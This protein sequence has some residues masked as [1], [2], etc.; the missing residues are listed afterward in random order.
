M[1]VER[2]STDKATQLGF[3]SIQL[4]TEIRGRCWDNIV[5]AGLHQFHQGKGY[6]PHS[7][8]LARHLD[9][10]IY[11]LS[12]EKDTP[13]AQGESAIPKQIMFCWIK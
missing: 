10:P 8:E 6:D 7:Q 2:L 9:L 12:S 4:T 11:R 3:S 1:G 13:F 5:Y